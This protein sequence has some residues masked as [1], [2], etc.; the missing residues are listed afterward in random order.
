MAF[1]SGHLLL[2]SELARDF[3]SGI[4]QVLVHY[5]EAQHFLLLAPGDNGWFAKMHKPAFCLVK[6]ANMNGEK[7]VSIRSFE[8]D[9]ELNLEDRE[10]GFEWNPVTRL[11]K[12]FV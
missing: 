10:L 11:I 3:L 7:M 1:K 9:Y 2:G 4:S 12:V 5:N 6:D 8:I